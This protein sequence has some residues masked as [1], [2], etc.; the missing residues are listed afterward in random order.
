MWLETIKMAISDF[1][2]SL[3]ENAKIITLFGPP[4]NL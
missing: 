2:I 3:V 4:E 1:L